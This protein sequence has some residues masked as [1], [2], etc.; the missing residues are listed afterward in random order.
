MKLELRN[1]KIIIDGYVNAVDRFSRPIRETNGNTI[2][3]KIMPGAFNRALENTDNVNVLLDHD[4]SH[5][6]ASTKQ[7]TATLKEDNIGLRATVEISDPEIIKK[8]KSDKLRGWS[9]GFICKSQERKPGEKYEERTIKDLI[10]DEIS[11]IDERLIP[12]YVGTSVE[13][14]SKIEEIIEYRS[15]EFDAVQVQKEELE[16]RPI[17]YDSYKERIKKLEEVKR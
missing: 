4:K 6:L 10:L 1:G 13:M 16:Q 8:A 2:I 12:C 3:E 17:N 9:F 15:G 14:R 5:V 11:L 7:G